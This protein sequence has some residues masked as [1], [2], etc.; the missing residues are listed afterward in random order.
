[1]NRHRPTQLALVFGGLFGQDVALKSLTTLDRTTW[2]NTKTL[3]RAAFGFHFGHNCSFLFVLV[4][5]CNN[6]LQS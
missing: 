6:A 2:T 1:M 5:R 3:F 4:R